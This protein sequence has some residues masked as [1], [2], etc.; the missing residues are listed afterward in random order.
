MAAGAEDLLEHGLHEHLGHRRGLDHADVALLHAR[1]VA[2]EDLGERL[3]ALVSHSGGPP[4][5][6]TTQR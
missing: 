6:W 3:S 4:F 5:V 2:D 1:G